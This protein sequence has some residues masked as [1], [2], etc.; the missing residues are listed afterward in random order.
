[1]TN[2]MTEVAKL[3]GVE[4]DEVFF[5][6]EHQDYPK[7]PKTYLKFTE[8]G[9]ENSV[10]LTS[11]T[12]TASWMWEQLITGAF[13]INKLPWKPSHGDKYWIPVISHVEMSALWVRWTNSDNDNY[14]YEHG[15]ICRTKEKAIELTE[16]LLAMAKEEKSNG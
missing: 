4:L 1:M 11:W 14:R 9:L 15:L 5:V 10:D 16:K 6:K 7:Y 2:H 12:K 3:L 8:N 13:K